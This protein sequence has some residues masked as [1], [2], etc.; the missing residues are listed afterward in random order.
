MSRAFDDWRN[1]CCRTPNSLPT[2]WTKIDG[3]CNDILERGFPTVV[4][5]TEDTRLRYLYCY[6]SLEMLHAPYTQCF[7]GLFDQLR[8][9]I[10]APR[11]PFFMNAPDYD[12]LGSRPINS[13]NIGM[14]PV[15][16]CHFP[17]DDGDEFNYLFPDVAHDPG[18][19]LPHVVFTG[20]LYD[21]PDADCLADLTRLPN[22][23][24]LQNRD[25]H[26]D[27][28][29]LQVHSLHFDLLVWCE[30]LQRLLGTKRTVNQQDIVFWKG[31][32]LN[33]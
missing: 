16:L 30:G 20:P 7:I 12:P 22:H 28:L 31:E 15:C 1:C 23:P 27:T 32:N 8:L 14:R 33:T 17:Y 19:L 10:H 2:S 9:R 24:S 5:S 21:N 29:E 18:Y 11:L 3:R 13:F 26:P 4:T 6:A 25:R